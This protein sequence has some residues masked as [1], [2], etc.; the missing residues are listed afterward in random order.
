MLCFDT[1][2]LDFLRL[3]SDAEP[4][5][6][7]IPERF[8][9]L[10]NFHLEK[11]SQKIPSTVLRC[12]ELCVTG[13]RHRE[14]LSEALHV[15]RRTCKLVSG[16][17]DMT[18]AAVF[19]FCMHCLFTSTVE[20]MTFDALMHSDRFSPHEPCGNQPM[21]TW[22]IVKAAYSIDPAH[23]QDAC[24]MVLES[25]PER[26]GELGFL[27]VVMN[28]TFSLSFLKITRGDRAPI[29]DAFLSFQFSSSLTALRLIGMLTFD[30]A[31]SGI[32]EVFANTKTLCHG[33]NALWALSRSKSLLE[34]SSSSV[35]RYRLPS[36]TDDWGLLHE[37]VLNIAQMSQSIVVRRRNNPFIVTWIHTS[38]GFM[39]FCRRLYHRGEDYMQWSSACASDMTL[40]IRTHFESCGIFLTRPCTRRETDAAN[41][42]GQSETRWSCRCVDEESISNMY[43]V[44]E[45]RLKSISTFVKA[46][47]SFRDLVIVA[48][49]SFSTHS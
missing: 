27:S 42:F 48:F 5:P 34:F 2:I 20:W 25:L 19:V 22:L 46:Q 7:T 17:N 33:C 45:E 24:S 41:N 32:A 11:A 30:V 21:L 40:C 14:L 44:N 9:T 28:T 10:L 36:A 23:A 31:E 16:S 35:E 43:I 29:T 18:D 3:P 8:A 26:L 37:H 39:C 4:S 38:D 6:I 15:L 13:R 12:N 1:P 49:V 47:S